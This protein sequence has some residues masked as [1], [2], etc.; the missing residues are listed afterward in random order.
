ML[1]EPEMIWVRMEVPTVNSITKIFHNEK[2]FY[3]IELAFGIAGFI[4]CSDKSKSERKNRRHFA[5][6]I[7]ITTLLHGFTE[8]NNDKIL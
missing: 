2:L 8:G 3:Q 6:I 7:I 1:M 5:L 4:Y